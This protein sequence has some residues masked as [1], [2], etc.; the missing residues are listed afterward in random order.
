MLASYQ[1]GDDD[2]FRAAADE[3]I[4]DERRKRHVHLADELETIMRSG[5]VPSG[6]QPT[7]ITPLRPLPKAK[8]ESSLVDLINPRRTFED[9]TLRKETA[10]VLRDIV[11]E[12]LRADQ[13]RSHGL[14]PVRSVLFVGP[15]GTGKTTSAESIAAELGVPLARVNVAAVVSSLLGETAKNLA[16]IFSAARDEPWV[17]LFDEFDALARERSDKTEHSELK[18]VVTT[19]LQLLDDYH[20]PALVVAATN[21]PA[22]LDHAVWRRFDEVVAFRA[23]NQ[24]EIERLVRRAF[25]RVRLDVAPVELARRLR[26]RTH[27]D[28]ELVCRSAMKRAVLRD[29][30]SVTVGDIDYA[31][32][33]TEER[34]SSIHT[35]QV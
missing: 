25:R 19:F 35:S 4:V 34:Q 26:G 23:P 21:H 16:S 28:V 1:R 10:G 5:G 3:V 11:E 30:A 13:L 18:R 7:R 20:G 8:D 29:A 33:R 6:N 14:Q 15:P 27:A 9:Q 24:R 32:K 2:G 22:V 17:L 31:I 12:R